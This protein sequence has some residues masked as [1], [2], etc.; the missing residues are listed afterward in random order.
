MFGYV[1][2][3][4]LLVDEKANLV[5][6]LMESS[7]YLSLFLGLRVIY[8]DMGAQT[9]DYDEIFQQNF[10]QNKKY[11]H[12]IGALLK[13]Q[14]YLYPRLHSSVPLIINDLVRDKKSFEKTFVLFNQI[15]LEDGIFN[16]GNYE[17]LKSSS[18]LKYLHIGLKVVELIL[19][20]AQKM[21]GSP[22]AVVIE[23]LLLQSKNFRDV[24]VRNV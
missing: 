14:T 24:L 15:I 2:D 13:Q 12:K 21:K 22:R 9:K 23:Q 10:V 1:V 16:E 3:K 6:K 18:K 11:L 8:L 7:A 4:F 17:A 19:K 5:D 20:E